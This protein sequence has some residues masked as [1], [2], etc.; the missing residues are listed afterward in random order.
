MA[1]EQ[2]IREFLRTSSVFAESAEE[3]LDAV[4]PLLQQESYLAG[5]YILRQ[6]GSSQSIYLLRSGRLVVKILR[7]HGRETVAHLDPPAVVGE[8]SFLTGKP[9]VADVEVEVDAEILRL[10][11]EQVESLP[12]R[13]E[14]ILRGLNRVLAERLQSTVIGG[15]KSIEL[16][17]VLLRS[18]PNW[19]APVAFPRML[20]L[21]LAEQTGRPT[22]LVTLGDSGEDPVE[23]IGEHTG[24]CRFTVTGR[25]R[26]L[27][28]Q[29]LT[30]LKKDWD[31]IILHV[32]G[33]Q[34]GQAA[35]DI[36]EFANFHGH[37]L[38]P[39]DPLPA[40]LE[41]RGEDDSQPFA[42]QSASAPSLP[43]LDGAHQL[44][45]DAPQAETGTPSP[46]FQRTVGSIARLLGGIQVGL[47]LGGGAAWG[48]AHIGVLSV[49]ENAGIPVDVMSGCSMGSLIGAFRAAGF[50]VAQLTD[51]AEYW[52][53]RTRRFIEWRFWRMCL[54]NERMALRTFGGYLADRAVNQTEV[55]YWANAVDIRKGS[56]FAIQDGTLVHAIRAS[57]ALPGLLP[58]FS[59]NSSLL[60]DAGIMDPVPVKLAKR[61]GAHFA[62][63][64]NAMAPVGESEVNNRY[65][66]NMFDVMLRCMFVMGH[67]IGQARAESAADVLLT[68]PMKGITMLDFSRSPDIIERGRQAAD[69]HLA[70]IRGGYMRLK[71]RLHP[72][73]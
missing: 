25:L 9:C 11:K 39:G 8:L 12:A 59:R 10:P 17:T 32:T 19:E 60:V 21:S 29:H 23:R 22:L 13:R 18:Y 49:L 26:S 73:R 66:F 14:T 46:R 31:N 65:P 44:I 16:P 52:R 40:A 41:R 33:S 69:E 62:I 63:A 4:I 30:A 50:T 71:N 43:Y 55:P 61:M 2:E 36:E 70:D 72:K 48:W 68:L 54:V 3:E 53:T 57:I 67:E 45:W 5:E 15:A 47:A 35:E 56:E 7:E 58:P 6:G 1:S 42:V 27:V 20:A 64:V 37:L 28:A 51:L 24:A 34:A 38:G